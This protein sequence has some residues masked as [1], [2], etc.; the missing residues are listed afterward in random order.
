[1]A[2]SFATSYR[3]YLQ[4]VLIQVA[5]SGQ[6]PVCPHV[7]GVAG[8]FPTELLAFHKRRRHGEASPVLPVLFKSDSKE[9][10]GIA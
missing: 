7:P 4:S 10:E 6:A 8:L 3:L 9:A 5:V 2:P 1:M